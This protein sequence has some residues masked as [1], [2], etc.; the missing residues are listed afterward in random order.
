MGSQAPQAARCPTK[1]RAAEEKRKQEETGRHEEMQRRV[2]RLREMRDPQRALDQVLDNLRFARGGG[3]DFG[4]RLRIGRCIRGGGSELQNSENA[5]R[6]QRRR[7][8][9][10]HMA[11]D[12]DAKQVEHAQP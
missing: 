11:A 9:P 1:H 5:P 7:Q 6:E 3:A 2:A 8:G 4:R 12:P 10:W